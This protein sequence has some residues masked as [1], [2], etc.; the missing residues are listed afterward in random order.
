MKRNIKRI[1]AVIAASVMVLSMTACKSSGGKDGDNITANQV[2]PTP[3]TAADP[4]KEPTAEPTKAA[5]PTAV[6][7]AEPEP[8]AVEVT[9]EPTAAPEPV[10]TAEPAPDNTGR[11]DHIEVYTQTGYDSDWNYDENMA[12]AWYRYE[13]PVLNDSAAEEYPLLAEAF[14]SY[15]QY[16]EDVTEPILNDISSAALGD[17]VYG[18][19]NREESLKAI[20]ADSNIVSMRYDYSLYTGGT[21]GD[22]GTYGICWDPVTGENIE[23]KDIIRDQDA[24]ADT[25]Y[26]I[27]EA[28][29]D[30]EDFIDFANLKTYILESLNN[31]LLPFEIGYNYLSVIFNPFDIASYSL[32]QIFVDLPF[33]GNETLFNEKYLNAPENY[34]VNMNGNYHFRT[35]L[36]DD[37]MLDKIDLYMDYVNEYE[38]FDSVTFYLNDQPVP[39]SFSF[40]DSCYAANPIYI[41]ANGND[42]IYITVWFDSDDSESYIYRITM[43]ENGYDE[44]AEG[45]PWGNIEEIEHAA[46]WDIYHEASY[47]PLNMTMY[48]RCDMIGTNLITATFAVDGDGVP[49][50]IDDEYT[51]SYPYPLTLKKNL[52]LVEISMDT[53]EEL[54]DIVI[55]E[56][57]VINMMYTDGYS[58]VDCLWGENGSQHR[59]RIPFVSETIELSDGYSYETR[60][61]AGDESAEELFDGILY[62]D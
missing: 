28:K 53:R 14:A 40:E 60:R 8:T 23:L 49:I 29:Y 61:M 12:N 31:N 15:L 27:M 56:G 34:M 7:T 54:G 62:A 21:H 25:V 11:P 2:T 4:T 44:N 59:V 20:R 6:P 58:Y 16:K 43:N 33:A 50:M 26:G 3:V 22:Y 47:D 1:I 32:G 13:Y 55:T 57:D 39:R 30:P 36:K 19:Y 38:D 45:N 5:E 17:G 9:P 51:F 35:D 18:S 48:T 46:I 24:F 41:H 37:G 52:T 42:F 10:I